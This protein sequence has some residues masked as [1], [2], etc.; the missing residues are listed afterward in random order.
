M[1]ATLFMAVSANGYVAR[2]DGREDFLPD[3][4]F[5]C[6]HWHLSRLFFEKI[7]TEFFNCYTHILY[8]TLKKEKNQPRPKSFHK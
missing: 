8:H 7:F 3:L 5:F 2:L 4:L 1:K 6:F